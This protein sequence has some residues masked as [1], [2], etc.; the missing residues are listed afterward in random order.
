MTT[1]QF[2]GYNKCDTCRK[3]K[4]W[5]EEQDIAFTEHDITTTPPSKAELT[6]ML[7]CYDGEIKKLFNTSGKVYRAGDWKTKVPSLSAEEAI[8]ALSQDGYLVKRPFVL[9][10]QKGA[11]GFKNED[12][13]TLFDR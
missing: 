6:T 13:H 7:A 8:D 11:V 10:A 12:W 3:A 1:V 9:N 5:L 2:Y 4:K